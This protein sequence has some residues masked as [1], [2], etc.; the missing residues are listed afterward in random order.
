[1]DSLKK[2]TLTIVFLLY[3]RNNMKSDMIWTTLVKKDEAIVYVSK[4]TSN[5]G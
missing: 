2:K 4:K 5:D 3:N 1:M